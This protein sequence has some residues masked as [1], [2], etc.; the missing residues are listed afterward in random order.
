MK[1]LILLLLCSLFISCFTEPKKVENES[2]EKVTNMPTE[3][4]KPV[5]FQKE[6]TPL[7]VE[8]LIALL[9]KDHNQLKE[10][11]NGNNYEIESDKYSTE[12]SYFGG[13]SLSIKNESTYITFGLDFNTPKCTGISI[14]S[15]NEGNFKSL[16]K[17]AKNNYTEDNCFS[18]D[19]PLYN[20]TIKDSGELRNC[21]SNDEITLSFDDKSLMVE[22]LR[23]KKEKYFSI[24]I[25]RKDKQE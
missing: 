16:L 15:L 20:E 17:E 24:N 6:S 25:S 21:L 23:P 11:A 8:I 18:E 13:N 19:T 2:V 3:Q 4:E 14:H 12:V 1:K 10:W 7:N 9:N 5:P 22:R